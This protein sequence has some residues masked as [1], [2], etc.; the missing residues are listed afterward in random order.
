MTPRRL[1]IVLFLGLAVS[2]GWW[3]EQRSE[4]EGFPPTVGGVATS[5]SDEA[6]RAAV[7]SR[8]SGVW[9]EA[10]ATVLRTLRDDTRGDRHQRFLLTV[11]TGTVLVAHNI[12][13][14]P[15]VPVEPGTEIRLRGRFEWNDRGGVI[16]WTHH[17]PAG[18]RRGGWI[19]IDGRR[20]Q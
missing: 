6:L 10:R 11:G 16:H 3:V 8:R 14:A 4:G 15:R 9:L 18:R 12:D 20:F 19:E 17:D 13:L 5:D 2:L 1:V 7:A